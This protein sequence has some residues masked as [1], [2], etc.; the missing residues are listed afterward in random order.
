MLLAFSFR[1]CAPCP[2]APGPSKA[3]L[4]GVRTS[5]GSFSMNSVCLQCI[6]LTGRLVM[7]A[8]GTDYVKWVLFQLFK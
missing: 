2:L 3:F 6:L 8:T 4:L 7:P 5:L 1:V